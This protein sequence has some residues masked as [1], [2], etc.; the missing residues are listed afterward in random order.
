LAKRSVT[1]LISGQEYRIRSEA[2]EAWLQRVAG[3]LDKAMSQVRERTGTVDTLDVAILTS[4]NLAR[5]V[6]GLR[7][8]AESHREGEADVSDERLR[9]L[10][11]LAETAVG[12]GERRGLAGAERRGAEETALLTLPAGDEVD[13]VQGG[14]L[15]P[16]MDALDADSER[17]GAATGSRKARS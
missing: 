6:L 9:G 15:G 17:A 2:D 8:R 10:I 12:N 11:E 3:Y 1:V 4:L 5:E 7:A 14:L 16:M 13:D